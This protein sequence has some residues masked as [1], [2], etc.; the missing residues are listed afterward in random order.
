V[1]NLGFC[2]ES[3]LPEV[4]GTFSALSSR[5]RMVVGEIKFSLAGSPERQGDGLQLNGTYHAPHDGE[6]VSN[7]SQMAAKCRGG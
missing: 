5:E 7:V 2:T 4:E 1:G 6:V 3:L